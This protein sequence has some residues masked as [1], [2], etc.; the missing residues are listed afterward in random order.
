LFV[1]FDKLKSVIERNFINLVYLFNHP[2]ELGHL[3]ETFVINELQ[4]QAACFDQDLSFYHYRDKDKI[5]VDCIIEN[6]RGD[7]FA[8]EVKASATLKQ[9]DFQGLKRFKKIAKDV[10]K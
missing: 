3:L 8:I 2:N 10:L 4:K 7:C 6:A 9:E 5:E 1:C